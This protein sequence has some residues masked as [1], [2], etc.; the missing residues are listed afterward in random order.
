M[1]DVAARAQHTLDAWRERGADRLDP[2]RFR[3]IDALRRRAA[4]HGGDARRLL[5][6]RL[7]A[8]IDAYAADL[9]R[10]ESNGDACE[11]AEAP[12][13]APAP[14]PAS[15]TSPAPT[16]A[17]PS[18]TT[19]SPAASSP[20]EPA[21]GPLA[22]LLDYI[23]S[24]ERPTASAPDET[25]AAPASSTASGRVALRAEPELLDYF[26]ETWSK[27][28]A[29]SQLRASLEQVP[30]NAGPLNSSSLVH[31][32]LS[33]MRELSPEYLRQFLSYVDALSWLQQM[34]GDE[35]ATGD[36]AARGAVGGGGGGAV[37]GGASAK[38]STRK[39]S[40]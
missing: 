26:R 15:S 29:D 2:V 9:R 39:R 30:K 34:N 25:R 17:A 32:S 5:D 28:S 18:T 7:A 22:A 3:F 37:V 1:D 33:L 40:R 16:P 21:R 8:L 23:G 20:A 38:K 14:A 31:R 27:L 35:A 6:A 24:R 13:P 36:E 12:A 11:C 4:A 19:T 10:A